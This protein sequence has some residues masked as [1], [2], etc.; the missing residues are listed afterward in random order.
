MH[1]CLESESH[2]GRTLAVLALVAVAAP[3]FASPDTRTW[4]FSSA[5]QLSDWNA[6]AVEGED[7]GPYDPSA[8]FSFGHVDPSAING[9][10]A[11]LGLSSASDNR[12]DRVVAL[13]D[14]ASLLSLPLERLE[15]DVN[16]TSTSGGYGVWAG[17][18]CSQATGDFANAYVAWIY[19][20][21]G[22]D[23]FAVRRFENGSM[24]G[25]VIWDS[26][27]EF[28]A[29]NTYHVTIDLVGDVVSVSG[30]GVAASYPFTDTVFTSGTVGFGMRNAG[31]ETMV[32][33][34]DNVTATWDRPPQTLFVCS[35]G[36]GDYTSIQAAVDAA[37][38]GDSLAICAGTYSVGSSSGIDL[39][40][41]NLFIYGIPGDP[42]L[43]I[44][45]AGGSAGSPS[46]GFF[47]HGGQDNRTVVQGMTIRNGWKGTGGGG[48]FPDTTRGG[49][50]YVRGASPI[51]RNL[52]VE[53]CLAVD[54]GGIFI[55]DAPGAIVEDCEIRGNEATDDVGG[56]AVFQSDN[57]LVQHCF[58]HH[59][60]GWSTGGGLGINGFAT[61]RYN[62]ITYNTVRRPDNLG[63]SGGVSIGLQAM[64]GNP[65]FEF[66]TVAACTTDGVNGGVMT[67]QQNATPIIRSNLFYGNVDT[68]AGVITCRTG[69][70]PVVSC[71]AFWGNLPG[72]GPPCGVDGGNNLVVDPQLCDPDA[73]DFTLRADSPCAD[74][75][76]CGQIGAFGVGCPGPPPQITEVVDIPNDQG[77]QVWVTWRASSED[78]PGTTYTIT[79]YS[80]WRRTDGDLPPAPEMMPTHLRAYP[81]GSWDFLGIVPARGEDYYTFPA[82]TLCD[83][84]ATGIC[85][86]EFFVSAMTPDPLVYFDSSPMQGYSVDNLVPPPPTFLRWLEGGS[87]A[88]NAAD[89]PDVVE[90]QV[91]GSADQELSAEGDDLLLRT[92]ELTAPSVAGLYPY[93]FVL[94]IDDAGQAGAA[95]I[96][97]DPSVG[98]PSPLAPSSFALAA[99][100]PNPFAGST[101]IGFAVPRAVRTTVQVYDLSGRAVVTLADRVFEPGYHTVRWEGRDAAGRPSAAGVYFVRMTADGFGATRKLVLLP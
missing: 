21:P 56:L 38:E 4:D 68:V 22:N 16:L 58:I 59:N 20:Q 3:A 89:A 87:L 80:I 95:S 77:R 43:V 84:T 96:T 37:A 67:I 54:G 17:Y 66:N 101:E 52:I 100:R 9:G 62:L 82:P 13:Y 28:G 76:S 11:E 49:G 64:A 1:P 2:F 51:L 14:N 6:F 63:Q 39:G 41:K 69:G 31:L 55:A 42:A 46:R 60:L 61:V 27:G 8:A 26:P 85:W 5:A 10:A 73:G 88:W 19:R 34:F 75:E 86:S 33:Q 40:S 71:N 92:R 53:D 97:T 79:E 78:A 94:A 18:F 98:A 32:G 47:I 45:D 29:G 70:N 24:T 74:D 72:D 65:V 12:D 23:V 83:S 15:Y 48:A 93:V 25:N 50:I 7:G 81:P 30:P 44:V 90:Y 35:D 57:A 99:G 91:W 36:S